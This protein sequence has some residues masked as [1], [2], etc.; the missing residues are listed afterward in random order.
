MR[1]VLALLALAPFAA[2]SPQ[3]SHLVFEPNRG[4]TDSAVR[5]VARTGAG[6]IFFPDAQTVLRGGRDSVL[7]FEL[8]GSDPA[9]PW[10]AADPGAETTSYI[11]GRDR[12]RWVRDVVPYKRLERRAVYPGIDMAWYGAGDR[13]EYDFL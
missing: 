13:L 10:E 2:A 12:S 1:I 6:P 7:R 11:L 4:Q 9:A 8:P 3:D 5:Y